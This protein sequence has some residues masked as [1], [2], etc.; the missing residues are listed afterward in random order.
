LPLSASRTI[1]AGGVIYLALFPRL[2]FDDHPCLLTASSAQRTHE[3]PDALIAAGGSV[4]IYQILPDAHRVPA[5][6]QIGFDLLPVDRK[7]LAETSTE[8]AGDEFCVKKPVIT[9]GAG[10]AFSSLDVR[11][12]R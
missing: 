3:P 1:G 5:T 2:G 8:L 10:F 11:L 9:R 12:S 7:A 6:A 4:P